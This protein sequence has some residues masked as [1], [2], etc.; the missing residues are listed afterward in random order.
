MSSGNLA[1]IR[2]NGI[3]HLEAGINAAIGGHFGV[4]VVTIS[5]DDATID[6]ARQ[7]LGDVEGAVV[8]WNYSFHSA[9]TLTP[10]AA[11]AVIKER[12]RAALGRLDDF[13]PYV[14]ETPIRLEVTFKNYRPAEILAYLPNVDR[15][16]AHSIRFVGQDMVEISRFI[17]FL[18]TYEAGLTP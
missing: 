15:V 8:K 2:L 16:D 9:R 1:D 17:E 13:R 14:L 18:G 11:Y 6:E 5:G 12:V 4:P 7:L 3:S 10:D